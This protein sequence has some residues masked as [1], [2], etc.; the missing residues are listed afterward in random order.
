MVNIASLKNIKSIGKIDD[1]KPV[2]P[3]NPSVSSGISLSDDFYTPAYTKSVTKSV[4][5]PNRQSALDKVINS[6]FSTESRQEFF[7]LFPAV[8][9]KFVVDDI[10][11][12]ASKKYPELG[13][14]T[15][16]PKNEIEK[17]IS[18][19]DLTKK[20]KSLSQSQKLST[21]RKAQWEDPHSGY[22]K[23]EY[24]EKISA[25][26]AAKKQEA[27]TSEIAK[28][29]ANPDLRTASYIDTIPDP[30]VKWK[31][32]NEFSDLFPDLYHG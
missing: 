6:D 23:P 17:I 25:T 9:N 31:V 28:I 12:V 15:N 32:R 14:L 24:T 16:V 19:K 18:V 8:D 4:T 30:A 5:K 13:D 26:A 27:A 21:K 11:Y 2:K 7:K 3:V 22:N 20:D 10:R 1:I 29:N